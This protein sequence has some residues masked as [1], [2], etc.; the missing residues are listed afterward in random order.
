MTRLA[1]PVLAEETLTLMVTWTDWWLTGRYLTGGG[2][3]VKA[4]M[5]LMGYTMWL[6]PSL[7][8][9]V[10]IGATAIIARRVGERDQAAAQLTANQ[11]ILTGGGLAVIITTLAI[12]L[13]DQFI[14]AMQL[15]GDAARYASEYLWIVIP[16]IPLIMFEQVGAACLRGAGD[17][18]TGFVAKLV[19]VIVNVA[20]SMVLVLGLGGIEPWGWKG[21][22]MGTA[23]GHGVG[24]SILFSALLLNRY[25][26]GLRFHLLRPVK[27]VIVRLLKIGLPGGLDV[28]ALLFS[29]LIFVA[30]INS[31][32]TAAAAAHGLAVQLEACAY[33]PA[34][35]FHVAAATMAGQFL[36]A[37]RPDRA[38]QSALFCIGTSLVVIS[39][40]ALGMYFFGTEL[41]TFF[42]GQP[43]HPT[44]LQVGR[45]LRIVAFALP[46][47]AI[48]MVATGSLRGAGDTMWPLLF[49]LAGFFLMRIPLA[50]LFSMETVHIPG[51]TLEFSGLGWGVAGAW[52]AMAIDIIVRSIMVLSR[53]FHG[54]WKHKTV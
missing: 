45:L 8:A 25:G 39:I 15:R 41:A 28:A 11:A 33:L 34:N 24:G 54:G 13:G 46:S 4:A 1:A 51:T 52:I 2:D 35:A 14:H 23:I 12:L 40:T 43:D 37:G 53:F 20:V 21:I 36:G 22:A 31:L 27:S 29:N 32:G 44:T 48:V 16:V 9:A 7:F 6:I 3:A 50:I 19:V 47:L 38:L 42:T 49:T 18:I 30:I 17:T 5:G 10:A 26:L